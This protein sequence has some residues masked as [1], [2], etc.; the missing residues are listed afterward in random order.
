MTTAQIDEVTQELNKVKQELTDFAYIVSHDL[1][2]PLR[3]IKTIADWI[4]A[5]YGEQLGEDGQEQ[6]DL[7]VNRVDRMQA[8]IDGVL[9]YSRIGRL[10]ENWEEL[11]L[12]E[13]VA[14]CVDLSRCPDTIQVTIQDNL[15]TVTGRASHM[16]QI[17]QEL[18]TN[19]IRFMDKPQGQISVTCQD[20][21]DFWQFSVTDNGPGIESEHFEKVFKI[22]QTLTARDEL[23]TT[24]VGLTLIKKIVELT[25]GQIWIESEPGQG[26]TFHF[27]Y[28]K[29]VTEN[30]EPHQAL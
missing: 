24:G 6:L 1:K 25:K 20:L 15:P 26:S 18:F 23:D 30:T 3:G 21:G 13:V 4:S 7:L 14:D 10:Q 17:F 9:Q 28:P 16:D 12:N 8:L 29:V 5:D 11:D 2:A 19:A 22:F 27:T